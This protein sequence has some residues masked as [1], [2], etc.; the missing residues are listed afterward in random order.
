MAI[1]RTLVLSSVSSGALFT[2]QGW[3]T[4]NAWA[5]PFLALAAAVYGVAAAAWR[6]ALEAATAQGLA[7]AGEP[8]ENDQARREEA[9]GAFV[10]VVNTGALLNR[11]NLALQ[12][13]EGGRVQPNGN[14][15]R[16]N[17]A[18]TPQG[19][20]GRAPNANQPRPISIAIARIAPDTSAASQNRVIEML[21]AG[22][23]WAGAITGSIAIINVDEDVSLGQIIA[24]DGIKGVFCRQTSRENLIK[25]IQAIFNGECWLPRKILSARWE[26]A[27]LRRLSRPAELAR[28]SRKEF[29]TLV[30]LAGGN[31]N[32][33]IARKLN[34]STHTVKSHIYN[35]F[36]KLQV[37]NR[38]QAV[39]WALQHIDRV[40]TELS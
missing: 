23:A 29:E 21:L 37:K 11:M 8:I 25:G 1:F 2:L 22:R 19:R 30:L 4:M 35:L 31:S 7:D 32:E 20:G 5:I 40:E 9:F 17:P 16:P 10:W 12:F 39:Q 13:T 14:G 15:R 3:H 36:R 28:L 38:V 34:V 27:S 26:Q 33:S 18:G 24:W 6:L